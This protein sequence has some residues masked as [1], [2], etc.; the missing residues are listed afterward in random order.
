MTALRLLLVGRRQGALAAAARLDAEVFIL[1]DAP[2][3]RHPRR[4]KG[5]A[6]VTFGDSAQC[7]AAARRILG[8][9]A[10][11]AVIALVE[12]AVL[13]A[14]VIRQAYDVPGPT[15]SRA[16]LWR[17]KLAMKARVRDAGI[18]CADVRAIEGRRTAQSLVHE[19]GLPMVLKPRNASGGRGTVF[20]RDA[21]DVEAALHEGWIAERFVRGTELS[22]ES[23]VSG[24]VVRFENITEYLRPGWANV[25][26]ASLSS[27]VERAIRKM[28]RAALEAL[29]VRDGL[30]HLEAFVDDDPQKEEPAVVFGELACRPPGGS[31][32]ELIGTSYGFD[33]WAAHLQVE[34]GR[35]VAPP[36]IAKTTSGVWFLHP[37][38]GLVVAV[39]G[40]EQARAVPGVTRVECN[41]RVGQVIGRREGT[42]QHTGRV[43]AHTSSRDE[44]ANALETAR[45]MIHLATAPLAA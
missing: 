29:E 11:D 43:V 38:A 21:R 45:S 17:D 40:L 28:N 42:G 27:R 36:P 44:T 35:D 23:I 34:L 14:A 2:P 33:P 39:D 24:G 10:P 26:P 8:D 19:L 37:G 5:F 31:L 15:V 16:L 7:V 41:V 18:A 6:R 25:V 13:P 30:T 20:A 3:P 9:R 12:R 1:D 4:A 32:M 22:I